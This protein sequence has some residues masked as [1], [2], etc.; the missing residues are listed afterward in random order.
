MEWIYLVPF[1][2]TAILF[3]QEN[4]VHAELYWKILD[5][6][7]QVLTEKQNLLFPKL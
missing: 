3:L 7:G 4:R 6:K 5:K 1:F 2:S